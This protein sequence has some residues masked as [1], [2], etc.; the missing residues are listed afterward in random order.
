MIQVQIT[1]PVLPNEKMQK[2]IIAR[3]I[4]VIKAPKYNITIHESGIDSYGQKK[5]DVLVMDAEFSE[6]N[7]LRNEVIS[8]YFNL[9]YK[10][11]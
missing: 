2:Q 5:F 6:L 11:S 9:L 8:E 4:G 7:D 10:N 3:I 1:T